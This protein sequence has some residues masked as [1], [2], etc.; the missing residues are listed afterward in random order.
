MLFTA[1]PN[2]NVGEKSRIEFHLQQLAECLG[3]ERFHLPVLNRES[4]LDLFH[5]QT[6]NNKQIIDFLGQHLSH[7][8]QEIQVQLDPQ[9]PADCGS[10]GG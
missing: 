4:L 7:D 9:K 10:G 1:K 8:S 2:V 5:S 6:M 3:F